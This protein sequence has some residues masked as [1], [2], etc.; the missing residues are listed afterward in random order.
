VLQR[1]ERLENGMRVMVET[2]KRAFGELNAS[3]EQLRVDVSQTA[4]PADVERAVA[5]TATPADVAH[6]AAQAVQPLLS[7]LDQLMSKAPASSPALQEAMFRL[8][9]GIDAAEAIVEQALKPEPNLD[10]P[11]GGIVATDPGSNGAKPDGPDASAIW[12]D[13]SGEIG[14]ELKFDPEA[15]RLGRTPARRRVGWPGRA[16]ANWKYRRSELS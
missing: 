16:Y 11:E 14:G 6:G 1:V 8:M 10:G 12:G 5:R 15:A 2:F 3:L 7:S 9:E 13:D 4:T